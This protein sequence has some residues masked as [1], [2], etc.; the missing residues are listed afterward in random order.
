MK[1]KH[2]PSARERDAALRSGDRMTTDQLPKHGRLI[3][4]WW[5]GRR[6]RRARPSVWAVRGDLLQDTDAPG[7]LG[8]AA[9]TTATALRGRDPELTVPRK[10]LSSRLE[11]AHAVAAHAEE[12]AP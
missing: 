1:A 2:A 10:A 12:S 6:L 11:L 3:D 5:A 8:V 4:R 7:L 9:A